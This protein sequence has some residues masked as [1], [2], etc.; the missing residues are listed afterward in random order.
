MS[1][2][3]ALARNPKVF[4]NWAARWHAARD[5]CINIGGRLFEARSEFQF[6]QLLKISAKLGVNLWLGA[7]D[8]DEEGVWRWES[9]GALVD[10][11]R[12]FWAPGQPRV[13]EIAGCLTVYPDTQQLNDAQ[14]ARSHVFACQYDD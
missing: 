3:L 9:D 10:E 14:C 1:I 11:E 13:R 4:P 7:R 12:R 2:F 5:H 8:E 6:H